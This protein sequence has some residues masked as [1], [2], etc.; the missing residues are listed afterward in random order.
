VTH[1]FDLELISISPSILYFVDRMG[2][3]ASSDLSDKVKTNQ[4]ISGL[5][6]TAMNQTYF[7]IHFANP[8]LS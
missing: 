2:L 1:L 3:L 8:T 6:L 5:F 7:A 4:D